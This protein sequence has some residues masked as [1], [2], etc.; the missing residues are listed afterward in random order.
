MLTRV[1]ARSIRRGQPWKRPNGSANQL[2]RDHSPVQRSRAF[3][4]ICQL[5]NATAFLLKTRADS[6][7]GLLASARE[8]DW[9]EPAPDANGLSGL[10]GCKLVIVC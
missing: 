8:G 10:L 2:R 7:I 9:A 4:E 5:H 6:F 1:A 3:D